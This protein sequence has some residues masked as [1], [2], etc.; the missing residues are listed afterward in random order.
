MVVPGQNQL[1]KLHMISP[2]S[3]SALKHT[4]AIFQALVSKV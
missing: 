2:V 4:H 3:E 1:K